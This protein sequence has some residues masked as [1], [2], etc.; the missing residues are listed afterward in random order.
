MT[1]GAGGSSPYPFCLNTGRLECSATFIPPRRSRE[2]A[3]SV[4]HDHANRG[5]KTQRLGNRAEGGHC[6]HPCRSLQSED[7]RRCP[8]RQPGPARLLSYL[9]TINKSPV[10]ENVF[11]PFFL[12]SSSSFA[13]TCVVFSIASRPRFSDY[14]TSTM[15]VVLWW[16]SSRSDRGR[17]VQL[18]L[19]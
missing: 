10:I 9:E 18:S 4:K 16:G 13:S 8:C 3:G 6:D 1:D 7:D 14:T 11:F 15:L 12:S 5:K 2:G 19:T 17:Q